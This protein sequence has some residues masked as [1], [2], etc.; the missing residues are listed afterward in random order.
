VPT[1]PGLRSRRPERVFCTLHEAAVFLDLS[2][3]AVKQRYKRGTLHGVARA[4][5]G[6][7]W[8]PGGRSKVLLEVSALRDQLDDE[9]QELLDA[10]VEG[11]LALKTVKQ[12]MKSGRQ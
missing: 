10:W 12:R 2:Y 1:K 5:D 3:N 9:V 7:L 4:I 11:R 8:T 6:S